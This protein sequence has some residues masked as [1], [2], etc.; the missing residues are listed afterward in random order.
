MDIWTDG[1]MDGRIDRWIELKKSIEKRKVMWLGWAEIKKVR[2]GSVRVR[3]QKVNY[4]REKTR[5]SSR[6]MEKECMSERA[7]A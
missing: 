6:E 1:E 7:S 2:G 3:V 4:Q 5:E